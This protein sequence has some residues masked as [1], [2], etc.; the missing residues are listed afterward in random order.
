MS[1]RP[2][3]VRKMGDVAEVLQVGEEPLDEVAVVSAHADAESGLAPK[4]KSLR[5]FHVLTEA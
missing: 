4:W 5:A 3:G 1:L 2:S